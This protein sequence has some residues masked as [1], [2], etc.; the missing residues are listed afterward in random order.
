M[1]CVFYLL[2]FSLYRDFHSRFSYNH[3]ATYSEAVVCSI[4]LTAAGWF[5]FYLGS[6]VTTSLLD[7]YSISSSVIIIVI[8]IIIIITCKNVFHETN[9]MLQ[10]RELGPICCNLICGAFRANELHCLLLQ[11]VAQNQCKTVV[12][13]IS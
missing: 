11:L 2:G 3:F 9:I 12:I 1:F 10:E 7:A 13:M 4:S 5:S 8:I 6:S